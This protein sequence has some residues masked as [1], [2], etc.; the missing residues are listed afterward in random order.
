V[1]LAIA[2]LILKRKKDFYRT[3]WGK[4]FTFF[5]VNAIIGTAIN[6]FRQEIIP[7]L[8]ARIWI[9]L[10]IVGSI[11]WIALIISYAKKL[12]DKKKELEK[13]KEFKKYL[14]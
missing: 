3:L 9:G 13:E 10:W 2:S 1:L 4:T 6:F 12:P 14:P 7:F 11:A 8:S 5:V